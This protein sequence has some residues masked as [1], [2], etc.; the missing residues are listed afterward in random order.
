MPPKNPQ[1][2]DKN[3]TQNKALLYAVSH[4][5]FF[6]LKIQEAKTL[7]TT[8]LLHSLNCLLFLQTDLDPLGRMG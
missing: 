1:K 8:Q 4:P 3:K 6:I 5:G 2:T 7:N